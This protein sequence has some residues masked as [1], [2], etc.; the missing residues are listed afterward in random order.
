MVLKI[1]VKNVYGKNLV[2]PENYIKE[3]QALT[4]HKTLTWAEMEALKKL[5][6]IFEQVD[7]QL[8]L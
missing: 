4:K 6:F 8:D 7:Y 2:Y 3:L 5:G 1:S